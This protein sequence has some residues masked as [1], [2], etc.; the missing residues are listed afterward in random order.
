MVQTRSEKRTT[1]S[2]VEEMSSPRPVKK[3]DQTSADDID[4]V[5]YKVFQKMMTK[6]LLKLLE[7]STIKEPAE[8]MTPVI[9]SM[10]IEGNNNGKSKRGGRKSHTG[11]SGNRNPGREDHTG[12]KDTMDKQND[13]PLQSSP[14]QKKNNQGKPKHKDWSTDR[15]FTPLDQKLE[16]VLENLLA[17]GMVH[18]PK[19]VDS[20]TIMGRFKEQFCKFHRVIGHDTE[21]CFV[22]KN[23]VQD[24]IDKNIL[25]KNKTADQPAVLAKPL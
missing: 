12:Q 16:T 19:V 17:K 22:L 20:P 25:G 5:M 9:F 23:I 7:S 3:Q 21:N 14:Q 10:N 6:M 15:K 11:R 2:N 18:L 24:R 4:P 13:R 8:K 1:S